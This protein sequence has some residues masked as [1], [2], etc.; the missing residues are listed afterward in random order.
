MALNQK[1]Y[2]L[3]EELYQGLLLGIVITSNS[4]IIFSAVVGYS[5]WNTNSKIIFE[6]KD[7]G[8]YIGNYSIPS[9]EWVSNWCKSQGYDNGWLSS[10]CDGKVACIKEKDEYVKKDCKVLG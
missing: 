5:L 6:S 9:N 1:Y 10:T 8:N 4:I 7:K 3:S 2:R